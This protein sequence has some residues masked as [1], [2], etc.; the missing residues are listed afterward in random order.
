M[1]INEAIKVGCSGA[2][3]LN[4]FEVVGVLCVSRWLCGKKGAAGGDWAACQWAPDW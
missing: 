1:E 2:Q 3:L 4:T